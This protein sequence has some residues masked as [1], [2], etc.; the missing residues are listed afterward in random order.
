MLEN[1][2][3]QWY[4]FSFLV[5]GDLDVK[6]INLLLKT[7]LQIILALNPRQHVFCSGEDQPKISEY[8][9][10]YPKQYFFL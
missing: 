8:F 6:L 9:L 5:T 3:W 2:P 4:D 1:D 7:V 10:K